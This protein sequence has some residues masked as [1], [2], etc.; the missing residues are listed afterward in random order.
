M[1]PNYKSLAKSYR[2][3]Y[4]KIKDYFIYIRDRFDECQVER[5]QYMRLY[6]DAVDENDRLK[7]KIVELQDKLNKQEA[8]YNE[9]YEYCSTGEGASNTSDIA[10]KI[11]AEIEK[12]L[13]RHSISYHKIGEI[14]YEHYYDG[15]M[16]FDIAE[17]KKKF[18]E[19][20]DN[21]QK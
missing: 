6:K 1:K 13:D 7:L 19:G 15:V 5:N 18:T 2:S 11:F 8:A 9:L 20:I 4:N 21:G 10:E 16:Q 17:L 14:C 12:I 3:L